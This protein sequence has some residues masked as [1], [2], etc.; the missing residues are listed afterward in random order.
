MAKL[1]SN[2]TGDWYWTDV[3]PGDILPNATSTEYRIVKDSTKTD[4]LV[5]SNKTKELKNK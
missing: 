2:L 5:S 4:S 3:N 1:K